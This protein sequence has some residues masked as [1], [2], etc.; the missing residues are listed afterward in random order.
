MS[1]DDQLN[2]S[3][4]NL[5]DRIDHSLFNFNRKIATKWQE[6]TY[7]DKKD[8]EKVL[9]IGS[10]AILA[11]YVINSGN[12]VMI[13]PSLFTALRGTFETLRP[14]STKHE[15]IQN[16][17]IRFPRRSSKYLN[18]TLYG[19]G[20]ITMLGGVGGLV[21]GT[22]S[23]NNDYYVNSLNS[24]SLGLGLLGWISAD[25][26]SKSDVGDPPKKPK[27][28]PVLERIRESLPHP[29]PRQSQTRPY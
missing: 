26:I 5:I 24:L 4:G 12:L 21:A 3:G 14:K 16:E 19:M 8:L 2:P 22:I 27:K 28:K 15:E 25:Y 10:S 9:Y 1:L 23:G 17:A 29:T 20:V 18:V 6:K 7:R 13:F 11:G